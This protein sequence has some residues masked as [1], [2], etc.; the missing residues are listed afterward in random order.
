MEKPEKCE[1]CKFFKPKG[2][3]NDSGCYIE[4]FAQPRKAEDPACSCGELKPAPEN[5]Q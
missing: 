5:S 3:G 1:Q 4:K 2:H